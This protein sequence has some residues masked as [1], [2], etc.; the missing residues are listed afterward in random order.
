[1]SVYFKQ[2]HFTFYKSKTM[3][4]TKAYCK[5]WDRVR[6]LWIVYTPFDRTTWGCDVDELTFVID[7]MIKKMTQF[8]QKSVIVIL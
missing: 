5:P 6:M 4:A 7:V 3:A 8:S 1:M 2:T